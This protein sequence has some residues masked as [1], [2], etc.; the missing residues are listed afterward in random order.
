VPDCGIVVVICDLDNKNK[1]EFTSQLR[2][3]LNGCRHTPEKVLF[4]VAI[5]EFEAWYLGDLDAIKC[6]YPK[7]K[8][9]IL[10]SYVNDSICGTWECLADAIHDGGHKSLKKR[11][12]QAIGEQKSVWAVNISPHM[13]VE[14]NQS[15]SFMKMRDEL[16]KV[17]G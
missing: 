10:R 13:D 5:E 6:A 14:N 2:E 4:C 17:C 8:D 1:D 11:G 9:G 15:P 16:R 3:V 7:A 12:W